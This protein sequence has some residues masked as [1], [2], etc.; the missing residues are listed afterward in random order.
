MVKTEKK[1]YMQESSMTHSKSIEEQVADATRPLKRFITRV[2][3][4]NGSIFWN[5][6]VES[7]IDGT[8][9]GYH[10]ARLRVDYELTDDAREETS[11][12]NGLLAVLNPD[13]V[14]LIRN[15]D[16][17]G[18]SKD[19]LLSSLDG[20]VKRGVSAPEWIQVTEAVFYHQYMAK[21][22]STEYTLYILLA[23]K[24]PDAK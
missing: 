8:E 18:S 20:A 12:A 22:E 5:P 16:A 3:K 4:T 9:D 17:V 2:D 13:L 10:T 7:Y 11:V 21:K 19:P 23:I 24:W 15:G 1:I 6:L 14:D